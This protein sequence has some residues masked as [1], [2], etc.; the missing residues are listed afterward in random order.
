MAVA[1][2][3]SRP[4]EAY[5][6]ATGRPNVLNK[7]FDQGKKWLSRLL[8]RL[9][10]RST[11]YGTRDVGVTD[12]ADPVVPSPSCEA[13]LTETAPPSPE[14]PA[15]GGV[16]NTL[17]WPDDY[18]ATLDRKDDGDEI[19]LKGDGQGSA[20]SKRREEGQ[21]PE[22]RPPRSIPGRRNDPT[23]TKPGVDG[24]SGGN[25]T[26]P[27]SRLRPE[28]ICRMPPGSLQWD[29]IL[30]TD[31][32]S[33]IAAVKQND[34][35]LR[36]GNGGW[37]L[38]SFAGRLSIDL[39]G[40][41]IP[42]S[43]FDK[44]PLIFK[45]KN[46]W[47]GDGRKV[48]RLTKGHFIVIAP[49]E[50][51]RWGHVP[52]EPDGCSDSAFMAHYFFRDG[53]ESI[54]QLGGFSGH[55]I[56]SGAPGFELIGKHVFDDSEEGELF[57]GTAP[58]LSHAS[59]VVWARVGE[60]ETRGWKGINFKPSERALAEVLHGRQGRFFVRVYDEQGAMLDGGQFRYLR[61]L[62]E[63]RMNGEPYSED[64]LLLPSATGHPPTTVRFIGAAGA[65][66]HA[67]LPPGAVAVEDGT[68]GLIAKPHPGADEIS[69]ALEADGGRVD[70]ALRLP[71]IWWR[72][73]R[74]GA[75]SDGE[76]RS[77]PFQM[78]RHEFRELADSN[79]ALR[80]RSP[81]RITSALV[82]FG[83]E[84][85]RK[86]ATKDDKVVLPLDHFVD[87][88][89]IDHRLTED[90]LFNVRFDQ[91]NDRRGREPLTL[92]RIPADP[93]P[94]IVSLTCEPGA[95]AGGEKSILSWVTRNAED[96]CA[97]IDPDVGAV[98]PFGVLAITPLETT[99]YT[100][101]LTVRGLE[102]VTRRATVRV[103]R[104]QSRVVGKGLSPEERRHRTRSRAWFLQVHYRWETVGGHLTLQEALGDTLQHRLVASSR[105][106]YLK[107]LVQTFS[108]NRDKVDEVISTCLANWRLDR[109]SVMDR[110]ILRMGTTEILFIPDLP[111]RVAIQ[112]SVRLAERYG[113][114]ESPRF[115]N[116]VLDAVYR[117]AQA[118]TR[119]T[120]EAI[121]SPL[122][123]PPPASVEKPV[124]KVLRA[125]GGWREGRGFSR[126][127]LR[128]VGLTAIESVRRSLGI[129]KRRRS[130]HP[131][132][133]ETLRRLTD[134]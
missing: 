9:L 37:L 74:V 72:M 117:S 92:I 131:A 16:P 67:T 79:A 65:P 4:E 40:L 46:N 6:G 14:R 61:G 35:P 91:S 103:S 53:S 112:E 130:E 24:E 119:A 122:V 107:R 42:V 19:D 125:G 78:T 12:V 124:A 73:E 34:E 50:W 43:L 58:R 62:R 75:E 121:P 27:K 105:I 97:A 104:E 1:G 76:W 70:I 129:D 18:Q 63:I 21:K 2:V 33:R 116:G 128:A 8:R 95:V 66:V 32:E 7:A 99:T 118:N 90:A 108:D 96:V 15:G 39:E 60:E 86:Y 123:R 89:Q 59:Q 111:G 11:C 114:S 54:E 20:P 48:P 132:N 47:T 101:R 52:V 127:E 13:T 115:V 87:Y 5:F 28:L 77:T 113:G 56:E 25:P 88:S 41:P 134:V 44:S 126:R 45:L 31:G 69:S 30:S 36:L 93:P 106:R 57:V 26:R 71:R 3:R 110:G 102:D 29:V 85:G 120:S 133:I 10:L 80:L 100:L 49:V 38:R 17:D 83:G 109:L 68:G 23:R 64:T 51:C 94:V 55:E 82:G 22:P 84:T 98:E 81:K